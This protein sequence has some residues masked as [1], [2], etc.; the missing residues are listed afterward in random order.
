MKKVNL[1]ILTIASLVFLL[2][3]CSIW[4]EKP[5]VVTVPPIIDNGQNNQGTEQPIQQG[6]LE[7]RLAKQSQIKKFSDYGELQEFLENNM[8][9]SGGYINRGFAAPSMA[10]DM[11]TQA[12]LF[13]GGL[14]SSFQSTKGLSDTGSAV[15]DDFSKTNVQVEG[16]DEADIIKT[17]GKYVYALVKNNL[18]IID[19]YPANNSNVLSAIKFES[20][21]QDIYIN[22]DKLVVFGRDS[23]IHEQEYYKRFKRRGSF[24]F[25]KVFDIADRT[26]PVQVRNLNVEGNYFNSRMIGDYVY[27]ATNNYSYNYIEDEIPVPRII[28]DGEILPTKCG[29]G[30]CYA[31]DVYYFDIP[32]EQYNFTTVN[33]INVMDDNESVSGEVY[34]LSGNQNM[35]VSQSN[36]Y[37]TYTKYISEYDLEMEV[38]REI[39]FPKM[40]A[41][42]QDR[43]AKIEVVENFILSQREK[44]QKIFA[45]LERFSSSLTDDEQSD[46]EEQLEK[47]MKEKYEDISKEL[48]KTVIHKIAIDKN[49]LTYQTFGEV[50]GKVLN[51]FSMDENNGYFRIATTKNRTWSRYEEN[52][53]ESYSN[54]FVLDN[55][56]K[57]VGEIMGLAEGERIYSVRFMQNRAYMVTF[58]QTDPLFVIDLKNPEKPTVLGELKIPGFSNY[59]HPYDEKLLIGIGKETEESERG[60]VTTK[61]LKLSLFDV[62]DVKNPTEVDKIELGDRGSNSIALND[63]RAFL[64]SKEKNLLV[65]PVTLNEYPDILEGDVVRRVYPRV[66]FR[67][68]AVFKIDENGF[69]LRGKIDHSN[70]GKVSSGDYWGGY[71]YYDDTVKR[72]LFIDDTLYTFSN[73]Y[74]LMNKIEDLNLVKTLKLEKKKTGDDFEIIN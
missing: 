27:F 13:G 29:A 43:I 44:N 10:V 49:K 41:K 52:R 47:R 15:S 69:E 70:G 66:R 21:P 54:M 28:D 6:T 19:A 51:Q 71:S 18:F 3:G 32:Y 55:N 46:L 26:N 33:A 25:F 35:Y 39:V 4:P 65:I 61:G 74:L 56:M 62:S 45:I 1:Q 8:S 23:K 68:A 53:T 20:R 37:I 50:T 38:V 5:S 60:R 36:I 59:L 11:I 2:A 57:V 12:D 58:K 48:E 16:V 9:S 64:F 30:K 63:H 34:L 40:S 7:E 73:N 67:G 14:E 22:D 31:P 72:S 24:T 17:D 42:D